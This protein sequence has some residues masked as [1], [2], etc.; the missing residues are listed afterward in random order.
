MIKQLLNLL[1]QNIGICRWTADDL[2]ASALSFGKL[3]ICLP[4]TRLR[5]VSLF[6]ENC[7]KKRKTSLEV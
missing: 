4:L 3:L 6:L 1:F 2:F 5:A 7:E